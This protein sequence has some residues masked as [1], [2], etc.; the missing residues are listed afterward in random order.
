MFDLF[1]SDFKTILKG[2]SFLGLGSS[3]FVL[4]PPY[5]DM[6][7]WIENIFETVDCVTTFVYILLLTY[8]SP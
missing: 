5:H 6:S 1:S 8:V 3:V 7:N 2:S 4:Y